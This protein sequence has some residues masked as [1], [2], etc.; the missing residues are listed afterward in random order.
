[1]PAPDGKKSLTSSAVPAKADT[2]SGPRDGEN[3]FARLRTYWE[4]TKPRVNLLIVLTAFVGFYMGALGPMDWPQVLNFLLGIACL[5][6]GAAALNQ[7]MDRD[8]DA[9]MKRTA[10]R[11]L[12]SG[13]LLPH[14]ALRFGNVLA[15]TGMAYL[16]LS[17]GPGMAM[18]GFATLFMYVGLYTPLKRK[19]ALAVLVGAFPGAMPPLMGWAAASGRVSLGGWALFSIQFLWQLPHILA[20]AWRYRDEYQQAGFLQLTDLDAEGRAAGRQMVLYALALIP[21]SLAPT[22]IGLTGPVYLIGAL[23]LGAAYTGFSI[24]AAVKPSNASALGLFLVSINYL[25]FLFILMM[26]DKHHL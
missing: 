13:R 16:W 14:E 7:F 22:F 17:T 3:T 10:R 18:L 21:A 11:P 20:I 15:L 23:A 2:F 8:M 19:T 9:A 24:R 6:G 26:L 1:M 5:S 25:S 4:L 12:P